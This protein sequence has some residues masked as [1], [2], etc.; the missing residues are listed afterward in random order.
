MSE[1]ILHHYDT[2]PFSEKVR[3]M[4]GVKGLAWR[5]V[6]QPV[7]MPKPDLIP[8]TG[9]Y[10]RIPVMQIGADVYCDSQVILAELER[11]FPDPAV[12]R[13]ADWAVN[14]WADRLWFQAS[15]AVIFGEIG[16]AVP[17]EFVA[18]REKLSGRPFDVAAMKAAAPFMRAQWR[19]YAA[20]IEDGLTTADFLGGA[21]P[22]LADLAAWMNVWWTGA[23][24]PAQA[25]AMLAGFGRTQRW[26]ERLRAIGHGRRS[27]MAPGDALQAALTATPDE[28]VACD[29]D[30]PSGLKR[31]DKVVVQAD[32]YGRDPVEGILVGL[33]RDRVTL[34][35]ECGELDVTHVHFPRAGYVLARR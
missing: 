14:L 32:D 1:I 31:G 11:R 24:A 26:I 6:I 34:A 3:L 4:L 17:K 2:S 27:A 20:W 12:V 8:L 33:T 21:A 22:S 28:G 7:I 13:G 9:G 5:S 16:D 15:V 19:A 18:D 30:D 29:P 23:A 25:Q 10:R 35:R